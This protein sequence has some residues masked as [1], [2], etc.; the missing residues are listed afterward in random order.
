[1]SNWPSAWRIWYS[2]KATSSFSRLSTN[3]LDILSRSSPCTSHA[4]AIRP[5]PAGNSRS[6]SAPF[7]DTGFLNSVIKQVSLTAP[8]CDSL[9]PDQLSQAPNI[10]FDDIFIWA[11][12]KIVELL[13]K[14]F[15]GK[16]MTRPAH[17]TPEQAKLGAG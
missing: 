1:M 15:F 16:N 9:R 17:Q 10:S 5:M 6:R 8:R 11:F 4:I 2:R 14:L 7:T 3:S 13:H 12:V